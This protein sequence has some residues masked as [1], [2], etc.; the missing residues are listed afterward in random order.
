MQCAIMYIYLNVDI[1]Q[2][3]YARMQMNHSRMM[4]EIAKVSSYLM[5]HFVVVHIVNVI[6]LISIYISLQRR[7]Q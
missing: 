4:A 7:I 5:I 6:I 1:G 2:M 3:L